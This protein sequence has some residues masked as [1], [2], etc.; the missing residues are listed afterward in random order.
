MH[1]KRSCLLLIGALV[2]FNL[3]LFFAIAPVPAQAATSLRTGSIHSIDWAHPIRVQLPLPGQPRSGIGSLQT[4][5]RGSNINKSPEAN[6]P[7][8]CYQGIAYNVIVN[9]QTVWTATNGNIEAWVEYQWCPT[10]AGDT[11]GINWAYGRGYVN[12]GCANIY[13]GDLNSPFHNPIGPLI[14]AQNQNWVDDGEYYTSYWICNGY[15]WDY[16]TTVVGSGLYKVFMYAQ[17]DNNVLAIA[18][19]PCYC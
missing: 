1:F 3:L 4:G 19:S 14:Q 17:S 10:Y 6:F 8:G 12:N 9:N 2:V 5:E 15:A 11:V 13:V 16:T 18:K 7:G